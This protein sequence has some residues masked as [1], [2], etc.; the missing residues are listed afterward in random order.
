[1]AIWPHTSH[2]A[3]H[4]RTQMQ[5]QTESEAFKTHQ[6]KWWPHLKR[7]ICY[8]FLKCLYEN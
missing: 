8:F 5:K 7:K 3:D 2:W 1:M 4:T 6:G